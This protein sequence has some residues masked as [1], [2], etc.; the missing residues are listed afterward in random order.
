MT[1]PPG[2][3]CYLEVTDTGCG[4]PED[5]LARIFDPFF[6]TKFTGRGL[7]LSAVLGIVRGH[8]GAIDVKSEVGKGTTFRVYFPA[9]TQSA[10]PF[11]QSQRPSN[12][13]W[14][15]HGFALL[16]DDDASVLQVGKSMLER[17]GFEVLTAIDGV[18]AIRIY[19]QR[20]DEIQIVILDLTMP[21]LDGQQTL[22]ELRHIRVDAPVLLSSGYTEQDVMRRLAGS[23][24]SGFVP[25]PYSVENL[26]TVIQAALHE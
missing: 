15:G 17:L 14:H 12:D 19:E 7:G 8:H 5:K 16:V 18:E 24:Y 9:S 20:A 21:N 4:I 25:K 23:R 22:K 3:Y 13:T 26:M 1:L 11:I 2:D 10:Q 6:T